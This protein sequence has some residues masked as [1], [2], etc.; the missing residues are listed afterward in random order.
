MM[1]AAV[2]SLFVVLIPLVLASCPEDDPTFEIEVMETTAVENGELCL[3][4]VIT[5]VDSDMNFKFVTFQVILPPGTDWPVMQRASS[6]DGVP[7]AFAESRL[8]K[9]ATS[10]ESGKVQITYVL[11][12]DNSN[13]TYLVKGPHAAGVKFPVTLS[14]EPLQL[15]ITVLSAK[16]EGRRITGFGS[17]QSVTLPA[18]ERMTLVNVN[19]L[20]PTNVLP[21]DGDW[22]EYFSLDATGETTTGTPPVA[23]GI[24]IWNTSENTDDLGMCRVEQVTGAPGNETVTQLAVGPTPFIANSFALDPVVTLTDVATVLRVSCRPTSGF[25]G[26][27]SLAA[28]LDSDA[29]NRA[30]FVHSPTAGTPLDLPTVD[31]GEIVRVSTVPADDTEESVILTPLEALGYQFRKTDG[32]AVE[33]D[34]PGTDLV[35]YEVIAG[36]KMVEK[37][38]GGCQPDSGLGCVFNMGPLT[39]PKGFLDDALDLGN[40]KVLLG[41]DD[42]LISVFTELGPIDWT[43]P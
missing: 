6:V 4:F 33:F 22:T 10:N 32:I 7:G 35:F 2:R 41:D 9:P 39:D 8:V 28:A 27:M 1:N 16:A 38:S 30:T 40:I 12:D 19:P 29:Q 31:V 42:P 24:I 20:S 18:A 15:L 5:P 43:I 3:D 14:A 11:P 17:S 23:D 25:S 36:D 37:G 34:S 13:G 26:S 21:V